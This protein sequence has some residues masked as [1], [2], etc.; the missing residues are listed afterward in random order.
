MHVEQERQETKVLSLS[1]PEG[2]TTEFR[3]GRKCYSPLSHLTGSNVLLTCSFR[4]FV[5]FDFKGFVC[6]FCLFVFDCK[7]V[8]VFCWVIL[9]G[10]FFLF[11]ISSSY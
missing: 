6:I 10:F 2:E 9:T 8:V 3:L 11:N 4:N 5:C 1:T 7:A